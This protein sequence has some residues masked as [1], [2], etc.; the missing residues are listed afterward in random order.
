WSL[1]VLARE[2]GAL[3]GAYVRGEGSPLGELPVQYAD[4]AQWQRQ[5]LS[6]E[7]LAQQLAYWR[8]RLAGAPPVLPLPT[9]RPRPAVRSLRG[10]RRCFGLPL[11]LTRS[12][13]D[14]A[15]RESATLFV[16]LLAAF[17]V[18]L[19]RYSGASDIVVGTPIAG[20]GRVELEGL[21][22]FFANTLVVR[23][24]LSDCTFRELIRR[25]RDAVLDAHSHQDV[26]FEKLV[27]ELRPP[28]DLSTTPLFQVWFDVHPPDTTRLELPGLQL[29]PVDVPVDTTQFD[30][31]LTLMR[32][33]AGLSASLDYDTDLFDGESVERLAGHL[34]SLLEGAVAEPGCR[35]SRLPLI[36]APERRRLLA[37]WNDPHARIEVSAR[38]DEL[39]E[40]QAAS[41]PDACAVRCEERTLTYRELDLRAGELARRLRHAG[42]VP[43][44]RVALLL[45]R[46]LEMVAAIL[47]VLK[48]GGAYVPLDAD[49]P[50]ER[51][52]ALLEDSGAAVI[53]TQRS[54]GS[55]L[56]AL[57]RTIYV[58][59]PALAEADAPDRHE[60]LPPSGA[61]YVIYTSGSTGRPKGVEVSHAN[62]IRLFGATRRW[63]D[64]GPADTWSLFHSFAFDVSVWELWGALLHGGSVVV[65]PESV[66]REPEA[67]CRLLEREA[68]TVLCQTPSSFR[69]FAP[70]EAAAARPRLASLRWVIFAGEALEP[71]S[72]APWFARYG[73]ERPAVVNMYGITETTIHA[74]FR[75]MTRRDLRPATGSVIGVP[76]PDLCLHLL[77]SQLQL[78]PLGVTGE[79]FVG[80]DGLARGYL[81]RPDLTAERFVPD[82]FAVRPGE[83]LYRS[84]DLARRRA[85]GELEFLGR[86]DQQLKIR[87]YRVEPAEI[88]A[89]LLS[90][91]AVREAL[92]LARPTGSGDP[93]L[94]A[95]L[96]VGTAAAHVVDDLRAHLGARL[97]AYMMP[98]AFVRLETW[99][100]TRNGKLDRATLP[101]P[102]RDDA[103]DPREFAPPQTP[104]DQVVAE[105]WR[106]VLTLD[107][108]GLH[109]D[110]FDLGGHSLLATQVL[111]RLRDTFHAELPLRT[112]FEHPTVAGLARE[113]IARERM[114]GL[115][116]KVAELSRAVGAMSEDELL[117]RLAPSRTGGDAA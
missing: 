102:G 54:Y 83:R 45:D 72:L 15:R 5:W 33:E 8:T 3:Y 89:A 9:D 75:R 69:G 38:L 41:T 47:A 64:F 105:I 99:P 63:F 100:L 6:G 11:A 26:P 61:A 31:S 50:V 86:A 21:V 57:Q 68:V 12:L 7:R 88:E 29:R 22:G 82:P 97:P 87:G 18:L 79:I 84:G 90:H 115:T 85:D 19:R 37:E 10:E 81:G 14:L 92:V 60:A 16:V 59:V 34:R 80:G 48:A 35:I 101:D 93:R 1:G 95:Y 4:Y 65:V 17:K 74:S 108:V 106:D 104:V 103:V 44:T 55:R 96:I 116:A 39:F 52:S 76:I 98:A 94:V 28:R 111:H 24:D 25:V 113:L 36:E 112:I 40:R 58:D 67:F 114:P 27:E 32:T 109:D 49:D 43:G 23:T 71:Q 46:S 51:W 110:F 66:R 77:D 20:R 53:L 70:T 56:R 107:R 13:E 78:V 2:V 42:V 30:L 62:V 117:R 91:P 73:D